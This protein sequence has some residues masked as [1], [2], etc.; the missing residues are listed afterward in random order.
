MEDIL[1]CFDEEKLLEKFQQLYSNGDYET[2]VTYIEKKM[3]AFSSKFYD[4]MIVYL[5]A[6]INNGEKEKVKLI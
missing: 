6:L 2:C 4:I 1:N 3:S 5:N